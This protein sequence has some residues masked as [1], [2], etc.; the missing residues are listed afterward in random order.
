MNKL[1]RRRTPSA[2]FDTN[3]LDVLELLSQNPGMTQRGLAEKTGVSLGLVNIILKRLI[4]TGSIKIKLLHGRQMW[5]LLTAKG[6]LEKAQRAYTY[7]TR[8]VQVFFRHQQRCD[9]LIEDLLA[10][11]H[12]KFAI[13]GQNEVASFVALSLR[14]KVSILEY[15]QIHSEADHADN[16]VLL[17]CRWNHTGDQT[18]GTAILN[19]ILRER[20]NER[21][22]SPV[23]RLAPA[24]LMPESALE[25][26]LP[27]PNQRRFHS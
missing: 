11:G 18:L 26:V 2:K 5:Y 13:L 8:T 12:R 14:S 4:E 15:R 9:R 21:T 23:I 1:T 20:G 22:P 6:A 16:E 27:T 19:R 3:V 7:F 10:A 25:P 17:D 24:L